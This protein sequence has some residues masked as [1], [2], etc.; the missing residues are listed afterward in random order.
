MEAVP[1]IVN[2]TS[3]LATAAAAIPMPSP[4]NPSSAETTTGDATDGASTAAA[5]S[6]TSPPS[7]TPPAST[8]PSSSSSSMMESAFPVAMIESKLK[9]FHPTVGAGASIFLSAVLHEVAKVV[10]SRVSMQCE[11]DVEAEERK[12]A[13]EAAQHSQHSETESD[14]GAA[15]GGGGARRKRPRIIAP[16][17][18]DE[19]MRRH[20]EL[21]RLVRSAAARS[22]R[23]GAPRKMDYAALSGLVVGFEGNRFAGK[24]ALLRQLDRCGV[25]ECVCECVCVWREW[26]GGIQG[27][28]WSARRWAVG[29]GGWRVGSVQCRYVYV[30]VRQVRL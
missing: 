16:K 9:N 5:A 15:G 17:H 26:R 2:A 22:G 8:S 21:R 23:K 20:T 7:S 1:P 12:E 4:P 6:S 28:L 30:A 14:T 10:L 11:E 27:V 3:T 13:A 24:T 25:C 29:T 19:T 18:I